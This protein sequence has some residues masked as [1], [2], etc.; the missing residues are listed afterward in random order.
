LDSEN[1]QAWIA[2]FFVP[3][4]AWFLDPVEEKGMDTRDKMIYDTIDRLS[5]AGIIAHSVHRPTEDKQ[6]HF[7][8]NHSAEDRPLLEQ[9]IEETSLPIFIHEA[10][11]DVHDR[12]IP[13]DISVWVRGNLDLASF[14]EIYRRLITEGVEEE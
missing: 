8:G 7:V 9:A 3:K 13:G 4:S 2:A 5:K 11:T 6:N 10:E 14:W 12:V 1:E